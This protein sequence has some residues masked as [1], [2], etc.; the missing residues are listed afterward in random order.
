MI[1]N[2]LDKDFVAQFPTA[3][4]SNMS[5]FDSFAGAFESIGRL[6]QELPPAPH[7]AEPSSIGLPQVDTCVANNDNR[8]ERIEDEDDTH[9][10]VVDWL[11]SSTPDDKDGI[12]ETTARSAAFEIFSPVMTP[13]SNA[14]LQERCSPVGLRAPKTPPVKGQH[15]TTVQERHAQKQRYSPLL[16]H[17]DLISPIQVRTPL[18]T[19]QMLQPVSAPLQSLELLGGALFISPMKDPNSTPLKDKS[20]FIRKAAAG[21]RAQRSAPLPARAASSII[22]GQETQRT[23]LGTPTESLELWHLGMRISSVEDGTTGKRVWRVSSL[24]DGHVA[25]RSGR[26]SVGDYLWEI[27]NHCMSANDTDALEIVRCLSGRTGK[28]GRWC[29][30]VRKAD[31]CPPTQSIIIQ[32]PLP[33]EIIATNSVTISATAPTTLS[34]SPVTNVHHMPDSHF[35][36]PE[37][38]NLKPVALSNTLISPEVLSE[39]LRT[40]PFQDAGDAEGIKALDTAAGGGFVGQLDAT[41]TKM[42]WWYQELHSVDKLLQDGQSVRTSEQIDRLTAKYLHLSTQYHLA[43]VE[44]YSLPLTS[45]L[46]AFSQTHTLSARSLAR[47]CACTLSRAFS[48]AVSLACLLAHSPP[49]YFFLPPCLS[50]LVFSTRSLSLSVLSFRIHTIHMRIYWSVSLCLS[51]SLSVSLCLSLS[52]SVSLCPL[53]ASSFFLCLFHTIAHAYLLLSLS[54]FGFLSLFHTF[55]FSHSIFASLFHTIRKS[56]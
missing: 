21:K 30:G 39:T 42:Q 20:N 18:E 48:L 3:E 49:L 46:L 31:T 56:I 54:F 41:R 4:G 32:L 24:V 40:L 25:A 7:A 13:K 10:R 29:L 34:K 5:F 38:L 11:Q 26:I 9:E 6:V 55:S 14:K 22:H 43:H 47:W 15:N 33:T 17:A 37:H 27:E 50:F 51:L 53:L 44:W 16:V 8:G 28:P 23:S 45:R 1:C 35:D 12:L 19:D 52:L 36:S 2:T